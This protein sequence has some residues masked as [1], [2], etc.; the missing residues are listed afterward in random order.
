MNYPNVFPWR[1]Y[2]FPLLQRLM[3]SVFTEQED[4]C[5]APFS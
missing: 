2:N 4:N 3:H 5:D 1:V